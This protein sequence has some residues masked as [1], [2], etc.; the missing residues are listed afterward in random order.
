[1]KPTK[2]IALTALAVLLASPLANGAVEE[3]SPNSQNTPPATETPGQSGQN[4]LPPSVT[5]KPTP[6]KTAPNPENANQP[7]PAQVRFEVEKD[8]ATNHYFG[9]CSINGKSVRFMAD[10]GA[11]S[12]AIPGSVAQRLGLKQ[13]A[14]SYGSTAS[15]TTETYHTKLELLELG[16]IEMRGVSAYILPRDRQNFILLGM[17]VLG[18]LDMKIEGGK[19]VLTG[20]PGWQ[21]GAGLTAPLDKA[22]KRSTR[23][24]MG[25]GNVITKET[26]KCLKGE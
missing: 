6:D 3:A 5:A 9:V 18:P 17:N 16:R 4:A 2:F 25:P 14:M 11:T 15:G 24:C 7:P 13:G 19:M 21:P 20:K 10:T 1:M 23:E 26:L 12:V 8:P 22:F